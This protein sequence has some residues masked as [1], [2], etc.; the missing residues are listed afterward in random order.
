MI[1]IIYLSFLTHCPI[2]EQPDDVELELELV[3]RLNYR[4]WCI[5]GP[6]YSDFNKDETLPTLSTDIDYFQ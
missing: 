4:I 5:S 6:Q 2:W 3:Y 1:D